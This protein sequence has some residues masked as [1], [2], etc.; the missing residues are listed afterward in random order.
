MSKEQ[1][2][3]VI[4]IVLA[5][6][7]SVSSSCSKKGGGTEWRATIETVDGVKTVRNP[8]TPR[9]GE[10]AFELSENLTIG[11]EKDDAYFF[12]GGATVSVDGEGAIYVCD[13]GNKRVQVYDRA[14]KY[15]R[16]LGRQGQGPGEYIFPQNAILDDAGNIYVHSGRFLVIFGREG[17]FQ[18]NIPLKTFLPTLMFGPGGTIVG[19]TQPNPRAEG[20]PK[21]ELVQLSQDGE[22]L[23]TFAEFPVYGVSKDGILRHWYTG[24]ISF[25]RRSSDSLFYGFSQEYHIRVVDGEGRK[26]LGFSKAEKALAITGQEKDLTREKGSFIWSGT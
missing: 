5:V 25:C 24:G 11:D 21:N 14:G 26:L 12:P 17:L 19:T 20:G 9:Y 23:R 6:V 18:K 8:E 7:L 3:G 2:S 4:V 1:S 10:F 16:T 15:V 13:F 22:R